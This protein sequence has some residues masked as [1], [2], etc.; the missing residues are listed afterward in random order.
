MSDSTQTCRRCGE[1]FPSGYRFCTVCGHDH[2]IGSRGS[3]GGTQ[4]TAMGRFGESAAVVV[5]LWF[6]IVI[7]IGIFSQVTHN[8]EAVT[9]RSL[10]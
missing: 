4:F 10:V 5:A 8:L 6:A 9:A 3:G 1:V 7:L 2:E